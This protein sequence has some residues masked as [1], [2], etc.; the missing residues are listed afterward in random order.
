[1]EWMAAQQPPGREPAT[2]T[3]PETLDRLGGVGTAAGRVTA[4]RRA[5]RT[6]RASIDLDAAQ[7]RAGRE[8]HDGCRLT[9]LAPDRGDTGRRRSANAASR[10]RANS[11]ESAVPA[12]G[13]ARITVADDGASCASRADNWARRR[14]LTRWRTTLGPTPR[15]TTNP[16]S[17]LSPAEVAAR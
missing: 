6:D 16:T 7:H 10:A 1:M 2:A 4:G 17:G 15:P 5:S 3:K 8:A 9:R 11:V 14:R 12:S 13:R